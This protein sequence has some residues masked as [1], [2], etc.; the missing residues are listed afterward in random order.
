V[1]RKFEKFSGIFWAR[2]TA[3]DAFN[4]ILIFVKRLHYCIL[5]KYVKLI[6]N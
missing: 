5:V 4:Y 6:I 2:E 3:Y 1:K